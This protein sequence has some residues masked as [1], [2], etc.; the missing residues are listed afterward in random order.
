MEPIAVKVSFKESYRQILFIDNYIVSAKNRKLTKSGRLLFILSLIVAGLFFLT[1][2]EAVTGWLLLIPLLWL[3]FGLYLLY[4]K[5]KRY[6]RQKYTLRDLVNNA[7][8]N[9]KQVLLFFDEEEVG[10]IQN[11]QEDVAKWSEFR[12]FLEDEHTVYLF[13]ENM[14]QAWSFSEKEIGTAAITSL[15]KLA[16]QK[17]PPLES[18]L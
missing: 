9:S 1:E 7:L 12:A 2:N 8:K 13:Q 14:Y 17:L 10:L 6:Q 5:Y 16:R 3:G 18:V 4:G 11:G 15:K